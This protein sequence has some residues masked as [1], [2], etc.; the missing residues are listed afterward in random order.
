MLSSLISPKSGLI[1][2]RKKIKETLNRDIK[3]FS[4]MYVVAS[5]KL[6]FI[7]EKECFTYDSDSLKSAINLIVKKQMKKGQIMNVVKI[8]LNEKNEVKA[9]LYFTEN[10]EKKFI[11]LNL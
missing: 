9:A 5:D 8:D 2:I 6:Q 1:L 10:N 3:A 11:N 4:L 7:I